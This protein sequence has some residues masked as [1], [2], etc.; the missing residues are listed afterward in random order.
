M[1]KSLHEKF[2]SLNRLKILSAI[3]PIYRE[4]AS[5]NDFRFGY[6]KHTLSD[7]VDALYDHIH[8]DDLQSVFEA[9]S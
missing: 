9:I 7:C 3:Y 1:K 4:S 5:W 6:R 2:L 8:P